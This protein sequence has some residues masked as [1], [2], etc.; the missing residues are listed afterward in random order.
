[1]LQYTT[2]IIVW[3]GRLSGAEQTNLWTQLN[4]LLMMNVQILIMKYE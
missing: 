1:M 4:T 3:V 2:N